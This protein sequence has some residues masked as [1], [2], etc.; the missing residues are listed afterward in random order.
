MTE[1]Y[2]EEKEKSISSSLSIYD[3]ADKLILRM[4]VWQRCQHRSCAIYNLIV[5]MYLLEQFLC[6]TGLKIVIDL[7]GHYSTW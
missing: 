6:Y 1:V 3:Q 4:R 7:V 5:K 2:A